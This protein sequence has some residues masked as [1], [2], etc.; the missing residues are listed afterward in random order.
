MSVFGQNPHKVVDTYSDEFERD[1]L[2]H[3]T[4][5]YA[6]LVFCVFAFCF[7]VFAFVCAAFCALLR[8][9]AR[10]ALTRARACARLHARRH[11]NKRVAAQLIYNEYIA[12]KTHV[13]MNG[14][15]T[16]PHARTHACARAWS[17][18][19][20]HSPARTHAHSRSRIWLLHL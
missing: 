14:T 6:V 19:R 5:G 4:M 16:R 7:C 17:A 18:Q 20:L 10:T 11:R 9:R 13:H 8:V 1:F 3:L 12:N 15:P 2:S